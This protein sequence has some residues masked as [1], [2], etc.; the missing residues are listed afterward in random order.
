[1]NLGSAA[2]K[3][4]SEEPSLPN[5]GGRAGANTFFCL[6]NNASVSCI[7]DREECNFPQE[8]EIAHFKAEN[9]KLA[10]ARRKLQADRVTKL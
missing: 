4:I 1:L 2:S 5:S 10:A 3:F 9:E 8:K 6:P 7:L